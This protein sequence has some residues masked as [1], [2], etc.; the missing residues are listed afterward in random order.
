MNDWTFL[1]TS[2]RP[3]NSSL[4]ASDKRLT[5]WNHFSE[6]CL[7]RLVWFMMSRM[8]PLTSLA[9]SW[10]D[11]VQCPYQA[12]TI[13]WHDTRNE[14]NHNMQHAWQPSHPVLVTMSCTPEIWFALQQPDN[15]T[16]Q[17]DVVQ[18]AMWHNLQG[19]EDWGCSQQL[20]AQHSLTDI[21]CLRAIDAEVKH[22]CRN[23]SSLVAPCSSAC[24]RSQTPVLEYKFSGHTMFFLPAA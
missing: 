4:C 3:T 9:M 16:L 24:C 21:E 17:G 15:C 22:L 11:H 12:P 2:S 14:H 23:T 10:S 13:M 20:S 1:N 5:H 6:F 18:P 8:A 19:S 7:I